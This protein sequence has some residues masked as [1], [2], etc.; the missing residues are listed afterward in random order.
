MLN[1]A[2]RK[3]P[4][5]KR[6]GRIVPVKK[7]DNKKGRKRIHPFEQIHCNIKDCDDKS[8]RLRDHKKMHAK[9]Y[10]DYEECHEVNCKRCKDCKYIL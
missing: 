4:V 5:Q 1:N 9:G 3:E 6:A 2:A 10:T 8:V 7:Q